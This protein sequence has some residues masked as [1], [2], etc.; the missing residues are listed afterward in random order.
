MGIIE[1]SPSADSE[2]L[3]RRTEGVDDL[4]APFADDGIA[5]SLERAQVAIDR[6]AAGLEARRSR[7]KLQASAP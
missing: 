5:D 1:S 7:S 6:L 2:R 4:I 3:L